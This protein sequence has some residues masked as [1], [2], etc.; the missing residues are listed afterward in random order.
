LFD[1]FSQRELVTTPDRVRGRLSLEN[2]VDGRDCIAIRSDE[3]A[4]RRDDCRAMRRSSSTSCHSGG[5]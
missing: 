3:L 1:A 4:V 5:W 2:A